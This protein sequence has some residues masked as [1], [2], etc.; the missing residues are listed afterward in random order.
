[1]H[2]LMHT[3]QVV[4]Q[5]V[6]PPVWDNVEFT[7]KKLGY[8]GKESRLRGDQIL[9]LCCFRFRIE[10]SLFMSRS[11]TVRWYRLP[12]EARVGGGD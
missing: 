4:Y 3:R 7:S 8:D 2:S 12:E 9:I 6:T 10:R 1:M 11:H 5:S